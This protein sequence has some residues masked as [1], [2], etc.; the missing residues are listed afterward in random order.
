MLLDVEYQEVALLGVPALFGLV[1]LFQD[2]SYYSGYG[3]GRKRIG[4]F[5]ES[6]PKL[7]VWVVGYCA[8]VLPYMIYLMRTDEAV[9][10]VLY[11]SSLLLLIGPVVYVSE[12]ERF[13]S[14]GDKNA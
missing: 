8:L 6:H 5:I 14:M 13:H 4:E 9:S 11:F 10:G 7:K 2:F 1:S 3:G 12:V